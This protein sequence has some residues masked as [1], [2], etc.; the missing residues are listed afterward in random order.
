MEDEQDGDVAAVIIPVQIT[1]I[2]DEMDVTTL[3]SETPGCDSDFLP[4]RAGVEGLDACTDDKECETSVL[5]I[6]EERTVGGLEVDSIPTND[7]QM[8][9]D[10]NEQRVTEA[11]DLAPNED[12]NKLDE[13]SEEEKLL[14]QDEEDI[15]CFESD[16]ENGEEYVSD[17]QENGLRKSL[18]VSPSGSHLESAGEQPAMEHRPEISRHS[19]SK[20]DTVSYRKI[21]KGNTKQRIDEFESMMNL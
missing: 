5:H 3:V 8:Q 12:H 6:E 9:K 4:W 18:S 1:D 16:K 10:L 13:K 14:I 19:Y 15:T 20:Y 7:S 11:N 2:T 21:R 17:D